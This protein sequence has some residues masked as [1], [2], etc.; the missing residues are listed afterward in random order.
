MEPTKIKILAIDD[1]R[2]NL[3]SIRALISEMFP[4]SVI[5]LEESGQGGID[6]ARHN[7]PDV[8]L[9]DIVMPEMDGYEVC[10]ILKADKQLSDTPVIFLTAL[11]GN[12]Q[13]HILALEAGGDAFLAKPVDNSELK[14]QINA[15]LKI[16]E[17]V[18]FKR[19]ER[20]RLEELVQQRTIELKNSNIAAL[21]LL[22]DL[23][24]E[25]ELRKQRE[26]DLKKSEEKF[27]NIFQHHAAVKLIIDPDNGNIVEANNAAA[28]FYGWPVEKLLKMNINQIN[29]LESLEVQNEMEKARLSKKKHFDFRHRKADGS[30][31][32][33]EVFSSSIMYGDKEFLHSIIHD[34][35][36]K[37]KAEEKLN[38]L[39][40]AIEASSVS[41]VITDSEG[42]I[43]YINPY[44]T[45]ITGYT[46]EDVLGENPRILKS[47]N[48]N[49]SFYEE[50]WSTIHSGKDWTGEFQNRKKNGELYWEAA[51][52]SPI[53]N[54]KG[55]LTNFIAI[56]EDITQRKKLLEELVFAKDKAE[57]SDKLKTAFINN[58]SHEIRT[59]LNGILGF[60]QLIAENE[61][62]VE[63]R[64]IMLSELQTSTDRLMN[65]ISDYMEIAMI[66]SGTL[67]VHK[68]SF[69]LE[70]VFNEIIGKTQQGC[71]TNGLGF[72]A[73]ISKN[74][75]G[76]T[77]N[78]DPVII[79]KIL[80]KLIDNSL[81]FTHE[82]CI[83]CGY[84]IEEHHVTFFVRDTGIG[85]SN[86]K[87]DIIFEMFSQE[88]SSLTRGHEGNGLGL[89][90]A[91]GLVILLGGEIHVTSVK[92]KG[93]EF[94]FTI[95]YTHRKKFP[96][97]INHAH[98]KIFSNKKALV[99]VA[100]D[101]ELNYLYM[102]TLLDTSGY[103]YIHA[104]NG[105]DAVNY[106]RQHPDISIVLMDIKMPLMNGIEATKL[107][108]EFRPDLPIIATTA[109]AQMGDE[110]RFLEAGCNDYISK[111]INKDKLLS[112]IKM[113]VG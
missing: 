95:P 107:I 43:N 4:Q 59:P 12:K 87:L 109:Y 27:R 13:S 22:E 35:S 97:I 33:V 49:N 82:G 84:S 103:T 3:I 25:N 113:N 16:K 38:L 62:A 63:D 105:L 11:K 96:S 7:D 67:K 64:K 92:G 69:L 98:S 24:A 81:K 88:D 83:T 30:Y 6:S 34:I 32:D 55:E 106:C 8:I 91:K 57:E 41:V 46:N 80:N 65:T 1:N 51:I 75:S 74:S 85:I 48:Q 108:R 54:S 101:D 17:A 110:H 94:A 44:F 23:N 28:L 18:R 70:P 102:R 53:M 47:G 73:E 93:S 45:F 42:K 39:N 31:V 78:S 112:I 60:G 21:N 58:I 40:R 77:L 56:K 100:E 52:I 66:V 68:E 37:K 99:L 104:V 2:D 5:F 71:A 89:S 72:K 14:A 26:S 29:A 36:E 86:D 50:L 79:K 90:I 9:L 111:P 10:K 20:I 15:M 19:N 76:L 61:L